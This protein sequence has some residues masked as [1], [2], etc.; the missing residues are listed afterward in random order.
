MPVFSGTE[1]NRQVGVGRVV[2][3]G[4]LDGR[5]SSTL[6]REARDVGFDFQSRCS[7]SPFHHH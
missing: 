5:M 4:S 2:T 3:L 6:A 1:P 7:V